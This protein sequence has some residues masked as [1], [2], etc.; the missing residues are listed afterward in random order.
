MQGSKHLLHRQVNPSWIQQGR[1][2]SQT[3]LPTPKDAGLLSV[4][5]GHQMDAQQSYVHYT[6]SLSLKSV[7]VVSVDSGQVSEVDLTWRPDPT[8]FPEHAVIDFSSLV[9]PSR[10]KAKASALAE[11]ARIRGW[12]HQP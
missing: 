12:T 7:G 5:D 6:T 9:S 3:F 10:M 1:F 8:P 4:Y 11:K 2:T